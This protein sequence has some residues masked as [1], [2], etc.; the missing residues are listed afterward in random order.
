MKIKYVII[1][2][3]LLIAGNFL[4]LLIEDKNIPEIEISK[5]KN[6]KKEKAKKDADLTKSNVKFD[7]NNVEYKDLLKLGINK[8]KAEKFVKYR[9]EV[10]IIK[11]VNEVKN[12]SG[13]GKSSLE[14]AQKFLFVDN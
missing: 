13:F 12:I 3:M 8:N 14:I 11:D 4:R 1:F 9:D 7:I 5:E 6:Y 2:V 10:G